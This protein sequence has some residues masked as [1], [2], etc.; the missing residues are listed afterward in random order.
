MS[1]STI[2]IG[3]R[4]S[5]LALQQTRWVVDRLNVLA[6]EISLDIVEVKTAGDRITDR[7]LASFGGTGAFTREL[8]A[9]LLEG[10]VHLAVHSLKDLPTMLPEGLCLA[11]VPVREDPRDA[12]LGGTC[13][14]LAEVPAGA[15]I[16]TGSIRR[17]A[18]LR[19][20]RPDLRVADIRG[21]ID[22][23]LEKLRRS[24]ELAGIVLA[25]AGVRRLGL[26][27]PLM[28]PLPLDSWLPA[29]GQG[30]LALTA[31]A[32]DVPARS[33]AAQL[34]DPAAEAAVTAERAVLMR[35]GGGCHMPI[36][37]HARMEAGALRLDALIADPE[38]PC[39]VRAQVQG[40]PAQA[41]ELGH[42]AAEQLLA[43][44][45]AALMA[46]FEKSRMHQDG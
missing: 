33:L 32:D 15:L 30:A 19:A 8:D 22:T 11:A 40:T 17:R 36:G 2:H 28:E 43:Q 10:Q 31:R 1:A 12:F 20:V 42:E 6:P 21:N 27:W 18:L 16:A 41:S 25:L 44:G 4:G 14:N 23:R 9:A 13:P 34:N 7:P 35:L 26:S 5:R 45:G 3:T 29:A 37:A 46:A 39:L 38:A 24:E